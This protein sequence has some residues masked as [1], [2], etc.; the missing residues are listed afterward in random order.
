MSGD[1]AS[2]PLL[3]LLHSAILTSSAY[4]SF[5]GQVLVPVE[6][7][8]RRQTTLRI[9]LASLSKHRSAEPV[10]VTSLTRKIF[11]SNVTI[12]DP[13]KDWADETIS[14]QQE[15]HLLDELRSAHH[16]HCVRRS[17]RPRRVSSSLNQPLSLGRH[18]CVLVVSARYVLMLMSHILN[19]NGA[20]VFGR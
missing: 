4:P 8:A 10:L 1:R 2:S 15:T 3:F 18:P 9:S 20:I 19:D 11:F 13:L 7:L 6:T 14:Q 16:V 5:L 12:D 17:Y